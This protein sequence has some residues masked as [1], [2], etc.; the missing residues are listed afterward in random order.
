[1]CSWHPL[2]LAVGMEW[3]KVAAPYSVWELGF[4]LLMTR[5]LTYEFEK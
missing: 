4:S 2:A 5:E 3:L 1:M